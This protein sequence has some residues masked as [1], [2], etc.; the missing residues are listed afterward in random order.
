MSRSADGLAGV[1]NYL[2]EMGVLK[3]ARRTGWWAAGIKDPETIAE[4]SFR[5]ALVGTMLAA[6]EGADPARVALLC[7]LHDTQ[8]T[9][10]GDIPHHG[11]RYLTAASNESVTADQVAELPPPAARA[12]QEAVAEYEQGETQEALVARDADKLE[13]LLQ[14]V[15]YQQQ[16]WATV[17]QWIDSSR[18]ALKTPS[19]AQL[20]DTVIAT[21]TLDWL[22]PPG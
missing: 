6:L 17:Q 1:A 16:G 9:R 14:A 15:E 8:E 3:R 4:H 19:A 21:G 20:A 18:A 10:V 13:C 5:T 12:V 11:R 7:L 22:T 2:V